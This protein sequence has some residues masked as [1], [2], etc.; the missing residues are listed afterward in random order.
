MKDRHILS[1][2]SALAT[3]MLGVHGDLAM[4]WLNSLTARIERLSK[5]W[6]FEIGSPEKA[7]SFNLIIH[8]RRNA[9]EAVVLKLG[10]PCKEIETEI[11]ALSHWDGRGA[12][13]L[14]ASD[15]DEGALLLERLTP[16]KTLHSIVDDEDATRKACTVMKTLWQSPPKEHEFPTVGDWGRGFQRMRKLFEGGTGPLPKELTEIAEALYAELVSTSAEPVLLHGDLHHW[17]VLSVGNDDWL[18]IDP[19]GVIG[20]GAYEVGAWLRNPLPALLERDFVNVTKRRI[21][22]MEEMLGFEASRI[23]KWAFA[24]LMLSAYWC[25]EDNCEG[26][27]QCLPLA[28]KLAEIS[29]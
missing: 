8:G 14:L 11:A 20:E 26:W 6:S 3:R 1:T 4:S 29:R 7:P 22:I 15:A 16:G 19:K 10:V 24:Q 17:N 27:E 21:A 2:D 13:R 28:E 23:A 5:R 25:I 18:A 9:K 12:V